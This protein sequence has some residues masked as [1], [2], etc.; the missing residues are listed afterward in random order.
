MIE[1]I[2][3][4]ASQSTLWP[5]GSVS[6]SAVCEPE[7]AYGSA[8]KPRLLDQVRAAIR[9]RHYSHRTEEAYV[10]WI[11]RFILFHGKRHPAAM[12]KAEIEQFLTALAVKRRVAASTQNQALAGILFLYK[13][14]L[15][16][17]PGYTHVL[18]LS[19]IHI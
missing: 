4:P 12:G 2:T 14:V 13:E 7:E 19:L 9:M 16:A 5:H 10:G 11:K 8:H 15:G 17:D 18:N 1:P 3:P 6:A